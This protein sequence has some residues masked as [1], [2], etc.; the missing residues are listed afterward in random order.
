MADCECDWRNCH[1]KG[2]VVPAHD[3]GNVRSSPELCMMCLH[4]CEGERDDEL[5]AA[6]VPRELLEKAIRSAMTKRSLTGYD[7]E[8]RYMAGA[9]WGMVSEAQ[10]E[11]AGMLAVEESGPQ[12]SDAECDAYQQGWQ[13]GNAVAFTEYVVPIKNYLTL[14]RVCDGAILEKAGL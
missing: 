3:H 6:A 12:R 13:M 10:A 1:H 7:A 5:D 11:A 2:R 14:S 9:V 8:F 4:C